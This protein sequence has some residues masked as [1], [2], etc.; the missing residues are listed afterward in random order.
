MAG[1]GFKDFTAGDILT[2]TQVDEYLM[3]QTVMRFADA[4][5]R[6]TALSGVLAEGMLSY[7]N[8]TNTVQVYNGSSWVNVGGGSPLT[9]K[10]DLYTYSTTDARLPV[11]TNGQYLSANSST[12][13]GLE[14]VAAPTAG[15]NWSL[16]NSGGTALTGATTITVSGISGKDKIMILVQSA[17]SV[18]A[19]SEIRIRLNSDAGANYAEFGSHF[20]WGSTYDA[21]NYTGRASLSETSIFLAR[22]A[23]SASSFGRGAVT[24]TGC[25]SSGVK[26]YASVGSGTPTGSNLHETVTL[27]GY[28]NSSSTISSISVISTTGNFDAGTVY[29]YTSA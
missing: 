13:T 18:N 22:M 23:N 24:L 14:W 15:S 25:N 26:A 2:A 4:T 11:G 16:L 17:S 8:D 1:A 28:Y 6:T 10:G 29:V 27:Q 19:I 7:L 9:T 12:A 21:G 3:Q 20:Q 5:A